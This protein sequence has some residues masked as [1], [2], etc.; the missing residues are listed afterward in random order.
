MKLRIQY[1]K[2]YKEDNDNVNAVGSMIYKKLVRDNIPAII[3]KEGKTVTFRALSGEEL[4]QALKDKLVEETKELVD[5]KTEGRAIEELADVF[6]VV[7]TL[8]NMDNSLYDKLCDTIAVKN[9]E[10]GIFRFG[11]FLESVEEQQ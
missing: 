4:K 11:Y 9:C 7:Q 8:F 1:Q 2:E 6:L 3:A 5:A 10:K